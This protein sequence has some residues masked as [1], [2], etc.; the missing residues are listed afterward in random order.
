[1]WKSSFCMVI[2]SSEDTKVLGL[3]QYKKS[4]KAQNII[5]EGFEFLVER[6]DVYKDNLKNSSTRKVSKHIP[7]SFLMSTISLSR[8][9][10][11]KHDV[12]KG[13]D[14]K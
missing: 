1:M 6:N 11:D 4:D 10:K 8:S 7:L 14:C 2:I 5:Y 9:K 3:N 13:K 12:Y